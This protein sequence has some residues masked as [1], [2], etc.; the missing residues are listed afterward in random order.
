MTATL[1]QIVVLGSSSAAR[2]AVA[3]DAV[4]EIIGGRAHVAALTHVPLQTALEQIQQVGSAVRSCEDVASVPACEPLPDCDLLILVDAADQHAD[5]G[6]NT[7]GAALGRGPAGGYMVAWPGPQPV[8]AATEDVLC[9][10]RARAQHLVDSGLFAL[11][12]ARARRRHEGSVLPAPA[13]PGNGVVVP[14]FHGLVGSSVVMQTLYR[15]IVKFGRGTASVLILGESGTGKDVVARALHEVSPRSRRPMVTLNCANVDGGMLESDLFGHIRGAYT[16]AVERRNGHFR[17]ADG[18]TL[19]LDE[20]GDLALPV[21]AKLLR[22]LESGEIRPVGSDKVHR[23]NVRVIAATH[24][25]LARGVADGWF[26]EDL[27]HR[28]AVCV[29]RAPA[30][31]EHPED[32]LAITAHVL[33]QLSRDAGRTYAPVPEAAVRLWHAY[34]WPGNVRELRNLLTRAVL[35]ASGT[36]LPPHALVPDLTYSR[37]VAA[38]QPIAAVDA[39]PALTLEVIQG[40]VAAE[41]GNRA[42]AARRLG[43]SRSTLYRYLGK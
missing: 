24:K 28:L 20:I 29:V 10:L 2:A 30:L 35:D 7:G 27:Y 12:V 32:I 39:A 31:R 11:A 26:R 42:R 21:Q 40:A 3:A 8:G 6:T 34:Q 5:P 23:V 43:I 16:G 9:E 37:P 33:G 38:S 17:E 19:F 1:P 41:G 18:G 14:S 13:S 22:T 4:S 36:D 15:Q 25:D